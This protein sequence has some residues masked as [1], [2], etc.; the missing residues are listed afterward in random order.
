MQVS[1][2]VNKYA[3]DDNHDH[4][5]NHVIIMMIVNNLS[6]CCNNNHNNYG[7]INHEDGSSYDDDKLEIF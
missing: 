1:H 6:S 4:D 7:K 3:R 5:D 2:R